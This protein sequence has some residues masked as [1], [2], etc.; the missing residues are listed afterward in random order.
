FKKGPFKP[1]AAPKPAAPAI[2]KV[3]R[4]TQSY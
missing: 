1:A 2:A 4:S 3:R